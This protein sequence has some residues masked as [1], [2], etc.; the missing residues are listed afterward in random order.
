MSGN[1][2]SD[3]S[4]P[5]KVLVPAHP[6]FNY[7]NKI[8]PAAWANWVQERGLYFLGEKDPKYVDLVSM[9]DSFQDN[10]GEKL[11]SLVEARVGKGRWMYL[12]LGLWR[13]LP[14]G[15]GRRV[16]AAGELA[17]SAESSLGIEND[18]C[19]VTVQQLTSGKP[20][21]YLMR[22]GGGEASDKRPIDPSRVRCHDYEN[23]C[24]NK[25]AESSI[26]PQR[27]RPIR[28]KRAGAQPS[29]PCSGA[30]EERRAGNPHDQ[31][32]GRTEIMS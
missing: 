10:P 11:G 6:A 22:Y 3:E 29:R 27:A 13:Q 5:V 24:V 25:R 16:P 18:H 7:P 4:V 23:D 17:Q 30:G 31:E 21:E 12:G 1:R 14:A 8:G 20:D 32:R 19:R 26:Q 9:T 15:H 2:V 28:L